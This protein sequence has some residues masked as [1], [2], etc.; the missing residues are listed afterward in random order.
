MYSIKKR[1][2]GKYIFELIRTFNQKNASK[3]T[4]FASDISKIIHENK[5]Y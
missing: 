4:T 2:K 3:N 1:C 5:S